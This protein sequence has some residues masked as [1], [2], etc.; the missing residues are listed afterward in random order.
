VER[1]AA[2]PPFGEDGFTTPALL[3]DNGYGLGGV[4][5]PPYEGFDHATWGPLVDVDLDG[6]ADVLALEVHLAEG[7]ETSVEVFWGE[8][9]PCLP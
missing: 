4:Y 8:P 5:G 3:I 9:V 6:H 2:Y 7:E 1:T